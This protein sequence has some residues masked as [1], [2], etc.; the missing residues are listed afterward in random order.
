MR[1][2]LEE[3][4][5]SEIKLKV[6]SA[7]EP[8]FGPT[9]QVHLLPGSIGSE[10]VTAFSSQLQGQIAV[11]MV[12]RNGH[13]V[14]TFGDSE[15]SPDTKDAEMAPRAISPPE[16]VTPQKPEPIAKPQAEFGPGRLAQLPE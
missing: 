12:V 10:P 5:G 7:D 8:A 1:I 6:D 14:A 13:V 11:G 2:P 15:L 4:P 16:S 3:A 9:T